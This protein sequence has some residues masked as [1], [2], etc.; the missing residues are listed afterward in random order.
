LIKYRK[1]E[2]EEL[3]R[4]GF[5]D[6]FGKGILEIGEVDPDVIVLAADLSD[7]TRVTKFSESFTD[8][9]VQ[10]GIAEQNM[11]SVASGLSLSGKTCF[12]GSFATFLTLR[13]CEQIRN[14]ICYQNCNV[15]IVGIDSGLANGF[16]GVTHYGL[17]DIA[18]ARSIPNLLVLSPSDCLSLAKLLWEIARYKGPVY[19]RL[20]GG[21][22]IPVIY[23]EDREFKI[24]ESVVLEEGKDISIFATGLMVSEALKAASIL[25]KDR[26]YSK[27]ID[28][29][30]IK[31]IDTKAI[32]EAAKETELIVAVEEHNLT[33]GLGSAIAEVIAD[34]GLSSRL[35]RIGL[36]DKF[37]HK[38]NSHK[39]LLEKYGLVSKNIVKKII[40]GLRKCY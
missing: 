7:A 35:L 15:K 18:I 19:L 20:S 32:I 11:L 10:L 33:G 25:K 23:K 5:R 38:Y 3:N 39:A 17:E 37:I 1:D 2:I 9:Y 21:K 40:E 16:L 14:D 24:G 26:I 31:P 8:R 30:T 27:V 29:H 4:T 13:G 28:V 22:S 12:C 6:T 34:H 36:P